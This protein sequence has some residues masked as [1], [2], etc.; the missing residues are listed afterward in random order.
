LGEVNA[1]RAHEA[2]SAHGSRFIQG[3]GFVGKYLWQAS[4]TADGVK[5]VLKEGGSGR[6]D[7][8]E[9]VVADLGGT[10]EEFYFA[11]GEDDVYVIADLPDNT[12]AAA[13]ALAVGA[14]GAVRI[15]TVVLLAPDE[16]DRAA[17][18]TVGYRPPGK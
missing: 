16:V 13:V 9:K 11:F 15:K 12:A 6:R 8:I 1:R 10:L 17:H 3:V 4:Y 18:T 5:G 7:A 2:Q 14:S